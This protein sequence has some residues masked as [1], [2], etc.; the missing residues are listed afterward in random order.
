MVTDV[1][2]SVTFGINMLNKL[3]KYYGSEKYIT[4]IS[5]FDKFKTMNFEDKILTILIL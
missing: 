3:K 2:F 1:F 4:F 5:E